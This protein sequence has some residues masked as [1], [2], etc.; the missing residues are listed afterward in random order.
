MPP[1][2]AVIS[3]GSCDFSREEADRLSVTLVPFYV[4]F[5]DKTYRREGVDVEVRDFYQE[6]VE[7]PGVYPKSS[8]PSVDDYI[9]VF[10][11]LAAAGTPAL[12]V[13]LNAPFSGS[14]QSA[15]TARQILL[16]EYPQADIQVLDSRLATVLQ[17]VLV[18]EAVHMRD[19]GFSLAQAAAVLEETRNTGR[20]FF[21]TSDL[22]Y[23]RHG[24]RIGKAAQAAGTLLHVKPLIGYQGDGL[25]TDGIAQ[26]RKNS[27]TRV[28]ELFYRYLD[29]NQIDLN[30]YYLVT[31]YGLDL[32][33]H[34]DFARRLMEG[35]KERGWPAETAGAFQIG[36]TIGVHTGP[37][38]IG[39]GILKKEPSAPPKT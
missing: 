9:Q 5:D 30:G 39:L 25:V 33:E 36:V 7:H 34:Q 20:I 21:T 32:E 19:R 28:M 35:L 11:P 2:F 13:C 10:R 16:E 26:G 27:L 6:M 38:P 15:C 3:D 24:G 17:G 14:F 22:D 18:L 29:R 37:T 23:L 31:G 8:M 1:R 12:C 4:S